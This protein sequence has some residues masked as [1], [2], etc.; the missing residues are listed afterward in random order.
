MEALPLGRARD[1]VQF[2][3]RS[4]ELLLYA[5]SPLTW[6]MT[7]KDYAAPPITRN[8]MV[9]VTAVENILMSQ[10]L[11]FDNLY[12]RAASRG[13]SYCFDKPDAGPDARVDPNPFAVSGFV[14]HD[15]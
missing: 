8:K 4:W 1:P 3:V 15:D 14:S 13:F 9:G 10:W 7:Q 11:W 5:A 6:A 12:T 2:L